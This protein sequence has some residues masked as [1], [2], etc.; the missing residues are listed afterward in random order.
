MGT[1]EFRAT[2]FVEKKATL[3][4]IKAHWSDGMSNKSRK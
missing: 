1:I 4:R 3:R 2:I